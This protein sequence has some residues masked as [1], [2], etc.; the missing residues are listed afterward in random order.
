MDKIGLADLDTRTVRVLGTVPA[1][2]QACRERAVSPGCPLPPGW[3]AGCAPGA[4][5]LVCS[6]VDGTVRVWRYSV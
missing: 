6:H 2:A 4:G 5:W 3:L 1:D